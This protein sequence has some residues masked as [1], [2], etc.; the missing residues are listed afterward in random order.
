MA[1]SVPSRPSYFFRSAHVGH[2]RDHHIPANALFLQLFHDATGS[3]QPEGTAPGEHHP[4]DHFPVTHRVQCIRVPG[5]G[6]A[7]PDIHP[8]HRPIRAEDYSA[9]RAAFQILHLTEP[10]AGDL[11]YLHCLHMVS[12]LNRPP[13]KGRKISTAEGASL[14]RAQ[15]IRWRIPG[16]GGPEL[17][18]QYKCLQPLR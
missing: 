18:P 6:G 7:P 3:I 4:V 15:C 12:S 11:M 17:P 14:R 10:K 1:S 16:L 9:A 2:H 8:G 5:A 13:Q